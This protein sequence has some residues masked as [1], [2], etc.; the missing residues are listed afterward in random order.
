MLKKFFLITSLFLFFIFT[1]QALAFKAETFVTIANPVRGPEIWSNPRQSPLD[2]PKFQYEQSTPS[3]LPVTWLLR[4]DAVSDATM[5]AFFHNLIEVDKNQS[6]G[7]FLEIT[8]SLT[9]AADVTSNRI[10]LSGYTIDDRKKLIDTYMQTF[11]TRLGFYPKSVS[12][13]DLDSYSLEYLQTKYSVLTAMNCDDQ[14]SMD[15]YR[16]WGGYL[17]S[18]YFPDKNNSLVP[19]SSAGNRINL[20]M[21]R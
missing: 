3:A 15:H 16:L 9:T 13:W 11:F 14:Y 8:P 4:F 17:G 10:F 7:A 12:A 5:S 6:L 1:D 2:L 20:A 21:V 19:A 18:P